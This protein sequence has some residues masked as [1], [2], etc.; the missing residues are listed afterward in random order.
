MFGWSSE[1]SAIST[2]PISSGKNRKRAVKTFGG[3][4]WLP[5]VAK[6]HVGKADAAGGKQRD[7]RFA[8][9]NRLE[10]GDRTDFSDDLLAHRIG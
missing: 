5:G 6:D 9:Q 7:A 3:K 1:T 4:G 10:T 2:R 8:P